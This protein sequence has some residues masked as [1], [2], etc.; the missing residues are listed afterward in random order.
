MRVM[1]AWHICPK[2][3]MAIGAAAKCGSTALAKA[4]EANSAHRLPVLDAR[5][6]RECWSVV[7]PSYRK[8]F[9]IR[10]P[11]DRFASLYANIQQRKRSD[12]NLYKQLEGL[13]PWDCFDRIL[14]NWNDLTYDFHFQP[15]SLCMGP[16]GGVE[17]VRLENFEKWWA[18]NLPDARPP[19][20]MN[21]SSAVE[22]DDRTADRVINRYREDLEFWRRA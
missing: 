2:W 8:V 21:E 11:V 19:R 4:I 14:E 10:H 3:Q 15:Q 20:K 7:P 18:V 12:Q 13:S 5:H 22:L 9:I 16:P 17:L 6:G 1:R